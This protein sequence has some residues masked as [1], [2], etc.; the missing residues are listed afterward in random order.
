MTYRTY[1]LWKL[2]KEISNNSLL[3]P[4]KCKRVQKKAIPK[5]DCN[6]VN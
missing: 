1:V 3:D 2:I 4:T 5:F 6:D